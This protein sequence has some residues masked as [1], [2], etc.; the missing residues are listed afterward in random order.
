VGAARRDSMVEVMISDTGIGI[1]K[2]KHKTIFEA[3]EQLGKGIGGTG[4]G[5][6][7]T[8]S[9][10]ELHGGKIRLESDVGSGS[11][12]YFTLPLGHGQPD[13]DPNSK[14]EVTLPDVH[15]DEL[16]VVCGQERDFRTEA[17][18]NDGAVHVLVVDDDPVNLHVVANYL[19]LGGI[20]YSTAMSG[21]EALKSIESGHGP[22]LV[23]L[24]LMMPG[25]SGYEVCMRL[26]ERY[27]PSELPVIILTAMNRISDL[28][29]GFRV[30]A[31]DYIA[32]PFSKDELLSRVGNQL[33]LKQAYEVVKDNLRLKEVIA[34][35][36]QT[37]K[38][39]RLI[40]RRLS[41]LLNTIYVA[42]VAIN[43]SEE[44]AFCNRAF[45]ELTGYTPWDL[46]GQRYLEILSPESGMVNTKDYRRAERC[47]LGGAGRS[48]L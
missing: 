39:L 25:M 28:V 19:T 1:P 6:S 34:Q 16:E 44:I 2:D 7:I 26:R 29:E 42:V 41:E 8:K 24:D 33:K 12:F 11:K 38:D 40:Q 32:K 3:F 14:Q 45:E 30:G 36:E 43:E 10:V 20:P 22:D 15:A 13:R 27:S 4:L 21:K 35:R 37:V 48:W 18:K 5:L 17:S 9:L 46:L 31:N 23:L 47:D